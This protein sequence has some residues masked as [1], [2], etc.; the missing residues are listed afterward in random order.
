M[1]FKRKRKIL[2]L[3]WWCGW[4]REEDLKIK[5]LLPIHRERL[6]NMKVNSTCLKRRQSSFEQVMIWEELPFPAATAGTRKVIFRFWKWT[7]Q[8]WRSQG[9]LCQF[10]YP[11]QKK[12]KKALPFCRFKNIQIYIKAISIPLYTK[13]LLITILVLKVEEIE[14]SEEKKK[15][16]TQLRKLCKQEEIPLFWICY[17]VM[18][19]RRWLLKR[20]LK[21]ASSNPLKGGPMHLRW[22]VD[23]TLMP[24]LL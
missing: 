22:Q 24:P 10:H 21:L 15:K 9:E 11:P 2:K 5:A 6:L 19:E 13:L 20:V 12:K 14:K 1:N 4:E 8:L 18:Q 23:A 3:K 7:I 16:R 17:R